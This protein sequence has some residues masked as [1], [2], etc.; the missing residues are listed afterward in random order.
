[1]LESMPISRKCFF[2]M[3]LYIFLLRG[4]IAVFGI[5]CAFYCAQKA[6]KGKCRLIM[7]PAGI[8]NDMYSL[9]IFS[10]QILI[11]YEEISPRDDGTRLIECAAKRTQI[12]I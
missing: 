8:D 6:W 10:V 11:G 3:V 12:E 5:D 9:R 7:F 2:A 1:M 4:I